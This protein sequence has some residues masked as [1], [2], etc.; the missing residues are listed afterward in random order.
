MNGK[1][2]HPIRPSVRM[3]SQ[4]GRRVDNFQIDQNP[5]NN[6][7]GY[8]STFGVKYTPKRTSFKSENKA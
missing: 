8:L 4:M 2:A 5:A 3:I 6:C 1:Y 7:S